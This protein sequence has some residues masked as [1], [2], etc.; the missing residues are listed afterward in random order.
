[1]L[2]SG[3]RRLA[4]G[5]SPQVHFYTDDDCLDFVA[6]EFPEYLEAFQGLEKDVERADFFRYMVVLKHGGAYADI[7]TECRVPLESLISPGDAL[8]VGYESAFPTWDITWN[9][10]YARKMQLE[11]WFFMAAPGHPVLRDLCDWIAAN[12]QRPLN[13]GEDRDTLEVSGGARGHAG[14]AMFVRSGS[15]R[16]RSSRRRV[17]SARAPGCGRTRSWRTRCG[18]PRRARRAMRRA[19]GRYACTPA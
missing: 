10:G 1:M 9:R 16:P 5:P 12:Y 19:S 15:S 17:R 4:A 18:S 7:D 3:F 8:V 11:Q 13:V 6:S 14:D 2:P